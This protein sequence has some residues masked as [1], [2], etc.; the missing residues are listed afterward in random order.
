MKAVVVIEVDLI[1][2]FHDVGRS[3][4]MERNCAM[5]RIFLVSVV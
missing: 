5:L 1:R 2:G 4:K 3:S